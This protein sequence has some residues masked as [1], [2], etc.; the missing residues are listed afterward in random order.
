MKDKKNGD[1][2]HHAEQDVELEDSP[3]VRVLGYSSAHQRPY[4]TTPTKARLS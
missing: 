2:S 4:Y 1:E 3:L